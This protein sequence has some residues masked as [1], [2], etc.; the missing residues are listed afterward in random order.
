MGRSSHAMEPWPP[1]NA[2]VN[3]VT[4]EVVDTLIFG[5]IIEK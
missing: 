5:Q 2:S 3:P 1:P 4:A